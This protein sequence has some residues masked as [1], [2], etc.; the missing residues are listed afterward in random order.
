MHKDFGYDDDDVIKTLEQSM[1]ELF[2]TKLDLPP[3]APSSEFPQK[4]FG[5]FVEPNFEA[6]VSE[7]LAF[8]LFFRL[9]RTEI[10][11]FFLRSVSESQYLVIQKNK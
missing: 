4:P 2:K 5:V 1:D 7:S 8:I 11:V 9:T 6:K 10:N 3:P